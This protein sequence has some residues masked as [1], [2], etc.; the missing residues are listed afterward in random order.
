MKQ[1]L[2]LKANYDFKRIYNR[3]TSH[4]C[5]YF[6]TYAAKGRKGRVRLGITAGKK[7]G[8][9]VQRNRA[10]RVI[11]AAFRNLSPQILKG[12][13]FVIVAR[14][15]ILKVKSTLVEAELKKQLKK[16]GLWCENE[17][18]ELCCDKVD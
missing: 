15:G 7:L 1:F 11:T 12:N 10:K 17:T 3:G 6:V 14:V 8:G 5:P 4:V 18:D 9:A 2:K 16:S 13:D